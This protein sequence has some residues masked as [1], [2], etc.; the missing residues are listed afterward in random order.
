MA[1]LRVTRVILMFLVFYILFGM[2]LTSLIDPTSFIEEF[3]VSKRDSIMAVIFWPFTLYLFGGSGGQVG[4]FI[5]SALILA[6]LAILFWFAYTIDRV[7]FFK[8]ER[9]KNE[10]SN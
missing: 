4:L 6:F 3:L 10:S 2:L 9:R 5:A 8:E 1:I 7:A